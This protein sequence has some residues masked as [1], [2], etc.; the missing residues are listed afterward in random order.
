MTDI[1]QLVAG[2]L[3]MEGGGGDMLRD[4]AAQMYVDELHP[5]ADPQHGLL[6]LQKKG[7]RLDLQNIQ[8]GVDLAGAVVLLPEKGGRDVAAAGQDQMRRLIRF[9]DVQRRKTGNLRHTDCVFIIVGIFG[10][11]NNGD[12][13]RGHKYSMQRRRYYTICVALCEVTVG[14]G[15]GRDFIGILL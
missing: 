7:E 15:V 4:R 13:G 1:V 2:R 8:F 11:S 6:L 3:L 5:F 14:L 9:L 12:K 10:T